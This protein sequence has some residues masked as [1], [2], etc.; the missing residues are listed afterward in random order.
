MNRG[1]DRITKT[2]PPGGFP[3]R[4]LR[5]DVR[6]CVPAF[7]KRY[8]VARRSCGLWPQRRRLRAF[9]VSLAPVGEEEPNNLG[10]V[11]HITIHSWALTKRPNPLPMNRLGGTYS[12]TVDHGENSQAIQIPG[13]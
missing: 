5:K 13:R 8:G 6:L 1:G 12:R 2:K 11:S 4:R 9:V 10:R 7:A 3:G